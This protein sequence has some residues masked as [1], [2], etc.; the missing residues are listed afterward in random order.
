ML[1]AE[2]YR[3]VLS[4]LLWWTAFVHI[5]VASLGFLY[6]DMFFMSASAR[7]DAAIEQL[8]KAK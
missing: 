3:T 2:F 1:T 8:R 5:V 4:F 6:W 7:Q